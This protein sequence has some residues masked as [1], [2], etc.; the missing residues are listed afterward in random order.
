MH[1]FTNYEVSNFYEDIWYESVTGACWE[2]IDENDD[3]DF[4]RDQV[5]KRQEDAW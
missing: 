2:I 1:P 4:I 3:E 5:H